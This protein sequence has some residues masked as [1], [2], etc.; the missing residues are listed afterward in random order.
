MSDFFNSISE[1]HKNAIKMVSFVNNVSS[2]ENLSMHDYFLPWDTI[3]ETMSF[4]EQD[5]P[6]IVYIDKS[7]QCLC[8][9]E[10]NKITKFETKQPAICSFYVK[11]ENILY[12][13]GYRMRGFRPVIKKHN[14]NDR[15]QILDEY[16]LTSAIEPFGVIVQQHNIFI[17]GCMNSE[18]NN[19]SVVNVF[20]INT[21]T[22]SILPD[23]KLPKNF[24]GSNPYIFVDV[25]MIYIVGINNSIFRFTPYVSNELE[26]L[27]PFYVARSRASFVHN[28]N[29]IYAIGGV[30]EFGD[31]GQSVECYNISTQM[32]IFITNLPEPLCDHYSF[33]YKNKIYIVG[34]YTNT[35]SS[36]VQT[37]YMYIYDII[38]NEWNITDSFIDIPCIDIKCSNVDDYI[39][40]IYSYY[41]SLATFMCSCK[42]YDLI[43]NH[44]ENYAILSH[45]KMP[46]TFVF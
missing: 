33:W 29:S 45:T 42:R 21:N 31:I 20:D 19:Y 11:H 3:D 44:W 8:V 15:E 13:I 26:R 22:I 24:C 7:T 2:Y 32:S 43:N 17:I 39:Y 28:K 46:A 40:V 5:I 9:N 37:K 27:R 18:T 12:G 25:C 36:R 1:T 23:I 30:N 41:A 16:K 35:I 10:N 6:Q 4:L 38:K 34:G 14:L